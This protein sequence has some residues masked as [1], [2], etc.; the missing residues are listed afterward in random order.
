MWGNL[1]N[2]CHEYFQNWNKCFLTHFTRF[3]HV[4]EKG[5]GIICSSTHRRCEKA[6][7]FSIVIK[8]ISIWFVLV[9]RNISHS[10]ISNLS[11]VRWIVV[12]LR[13][14][15]MKRRYK[16]LILTVYCTLVYTYTLYTVQNKI[17]EAYIRTLEKIRWLIKP[18]AMVR[19]RYCVYIMRKL[20][21]CEYKSFKRNNCKKGR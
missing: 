20:S 13:P 9:L 15:G 6:R 1:S 12:S 2:S 14:R 21:T 16:N 10:F 17:W 7:L 18:Y 19:S 4:Q 5:V 3:L 11:T 8:K